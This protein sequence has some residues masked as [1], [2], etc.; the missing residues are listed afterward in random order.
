VNGKPGDHPITDIAIH[1]L[2]VF[3]EPTD[4]ELHQIIDLLG[5]DCACDWFDDLRQFSAQRQWDLITRKL[6]ELR[7]DA[8]QRGL[9]VS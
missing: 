4:V 6:A 5:Y 3:G 7:E 2:A 1:H 8:R 9:E